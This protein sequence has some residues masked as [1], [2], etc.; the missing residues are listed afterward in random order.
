MDNIMLNVTWMTLSQ[1]SRALCWII[2]SFFLQ[3]YDFYVKFNMHWKVSALIETTRHTLIPNTLNYHYKLEHRWLKKWK[4]IESLLCQNK[5]KSLHFLVE[6][7]YAHVSSHTCA[8][9]HTHT[10]TEKPGSLSLFSGT[11]TKKNSKLTELNKWF[12][13]HVFSL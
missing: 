3:T 7:V 9:T 8:H 4:H 6:V 2:T 5:H 1:I 13:W 10:H 11:F 12:I